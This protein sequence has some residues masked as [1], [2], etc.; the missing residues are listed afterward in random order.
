MLNE[1]S[2]IAFPKKLYTSIGELQDDLDEWIRSYNEERPIKAA[3]VSA[4]RRRKHSLTPS[5]L[6]GKK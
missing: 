2:R 1:F 6:R 5:P 4:R 3:G